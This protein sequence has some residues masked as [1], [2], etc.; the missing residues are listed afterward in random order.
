MIEFFVYIWGDCIYYGLLFGIA[1]LFSVLFLGLV[2]RLVNYYN[3]VS[4]EY[5]RLGYAITLE[6][7]GEMAQHQNQSYACYAALLDGL[8][9]I[10]STVYYGNSYIML[11]GT[12]SNR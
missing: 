2:V 3:L 8:K 4:L 6:S 12:S 10:N 7:I 9:C 1:I 5:S 11:E